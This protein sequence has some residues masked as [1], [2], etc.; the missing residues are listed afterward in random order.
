[1]RALK[2]R[3][4]FA[5]LPR[6][7][8]ESLRL[9]GKDSL[10][11]GEAMPR[12]ERGAAAPEDKEV[13]AER[14]SLSAQPRGKAAG[15]ESHIGLRAFLLTVS[16]LTLTLLFSACNTAPAPSAIDERAAANNRENV[17]APNISASP[18]TNAMSAGDPVDTS[19]QDAEIR[20]HERAANSTG[21]GREEAR[22]ALAN[23]HFERAVL[24]T[25]VRQY[26]AA[27]GDYRRTLQYDAN[28]EEARQMSAQITNIIRGYGREVPAP[29]TEPTPLSVPR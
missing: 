5:A 29:G 21:R 3:F 22:Q 17:N 24:L 19:R 20:R 28:N 18:M 1:M 4:F 25:R 6:G 13:V 23:A 11:S 8:A 10:A 16:C 9:S 7:C 14:P 15:K 26:R 27:L 12:T 2:A